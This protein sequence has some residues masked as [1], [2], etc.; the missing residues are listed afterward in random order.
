MWEGEEQRQK[1]KKKKKCRNVDRAG[2]K[3][4]S[5]ETLGAGTGQVKGITRDS[6]NWTRG[7]ERDTDSGNRTQGRKRGTGQ[8]QQDTG[9]GKG[10]TQDSSNWTQGRER[11]TGQ[12]QQDM[13]SQAEATRERIT[14][15][16]EGT[17]IDPGEYNSPDLTVGEE[18]T[19]RWGQ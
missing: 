1:Q 2:T 13:C 4:K 7:R 17:Y 6:S 5:V 18:V 11:D 16:P 14:Y 3:G 19:T 12:R 9:Q 8:W 10:I 15:C